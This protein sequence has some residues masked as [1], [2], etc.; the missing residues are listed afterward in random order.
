[1]KISIISIGKTN[2]AYLNEGIKI[3]LSRLKHYT[4]IEWIELKDVKNSNKLAAL[5]LKK[6]EGEILLSKLDNSDFLFLLD[7]A[8]KNY[9]SRDFSKVIESQ[10]LNAAKHLVFHI[11]GAYGFSDE[12]YAR[13]NQKISLSKMTFSHQMVRLIFAEQ[14][15][16]AFSI[17]KGE[18]YHHD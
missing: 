10:M 8:G 2:E 9:S 7:E 17:I 4:N 1:M 16:R 12:V 13:A 15:Y 3:Y 11:G 14:L 18:K 5:E 6:K